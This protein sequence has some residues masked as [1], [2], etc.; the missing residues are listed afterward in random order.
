M[1]VQWPSL[2]SVL[3]CSA[4][5]VLVHLSLCLASARPMGGYD[6]LSNF[7]F[8]G[9]KR[10]GSNLQ[11]FSPALGGIH[12]API[13]MSNNAERPYQV[14]GDTFPDFATAA[15]RSCDVQHN[16][17]CDAANAQKAG[18]FSVTDCD[19]QLCMLTFLGRLG[20]R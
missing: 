11:S 5:F 4:V 20:I 17:C 8:V 2:A 9:A 16:S 6:G 12:A 13:T 10:A 14:M 18:N 15:G 3:R 7:V 1:A 19:N